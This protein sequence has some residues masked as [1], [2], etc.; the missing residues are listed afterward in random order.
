MTLRLFDTQG[1]EVGSRSI[2]GFP[3]KG[4]MS[5]FVDELFDGV[6]T[7]GLRGSLAVQAEGGL[8]AA[9]GLELGGHPGQ[10]TT[11]PVTPLS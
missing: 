10:F 3:A 7:Q 2:E 9:T 5:R 6:D 8:I 1:R 4:H 11:L